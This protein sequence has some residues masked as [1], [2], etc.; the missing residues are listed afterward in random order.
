MEKDELTKVYKNLC[1]FPNLITNLDIKKL[2]EIRNITLNSLIKSPRTRVITEDSAEVSQPISYDEFESMLMAIA[3]KTFNPNGFNDNKTVNIA[4]S[5][6]LSHIKNSAKI[7][8]QVNLTTE[9]KYA[10]KPY[11]ESSKLSPEKLVKSKYSDKL[12][13]IDKNNTVDY[14]MGAN[15]MS[16]DHIVR[17]DLQSNQN[18]IQ[19][20]EDHDND[21]IVEYGSKSVSL[22]ENSRVL[23]QNTFAKVNERIFKNSNERCILEKRNSSATEN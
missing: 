12:I 15:N 14:S 11:Y 3:N 6:L 22:L 23:S 17:R 21:S 20:I 19:I 18:E 7:V 2:V 16:L 13:K 1:I 5:E 4:I 9:S 8:Y 10:F